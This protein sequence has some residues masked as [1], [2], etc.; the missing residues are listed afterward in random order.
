MRTIYRTCEPE[1]LV[2]NA[3]SNKGLTQF[4]A[5]QY[6]KQVKYGSGVVLTN[7]TGNLSLVNGSALWTNPLTDIRWAVGFKITYAAGGQTLVGW[8]YHTGSGHTYDADLLGAWTNHGAVPYDTFTAGVGSAIT[9][10]V[11]DGAAVALGYKETAMAT[12]ALYELVRTVALASGTNPRWGF[13][14]GAGLEAPSVLFDP[15]GTGTVY[16]TAAN[17]YTHTAFYHAAGEVGDFALS[18]MLLR[19]VTAPSNT[20]IVIVDTQGGTTQNWSSNS[21]IDPNAA[22]FTLTI[23]RS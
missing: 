12:G 3:L 11:T 8:G 16:H 22:S 9:Q 14:S 13:G 15:A 10:A 19:K 4:E 5:D 1:T 18:N 6:I 2:Y 20:G 23:E 7:Q 17:N 21:G